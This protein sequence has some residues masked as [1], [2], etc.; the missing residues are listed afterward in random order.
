[1][2]TY[3]NKADKVTWKEFFQV[4]MVIAFP[5]A[6]Q[7][8]L[9]TTASMVDTIMIGSEGELAVAAVGIC[10]QIS[11]LYFNCYWGF[12]SGSVLFFSQYWGA[13]DEEG[14][15]RTLGISFFFMAVVAV[16]FSSVCIVFPDKMLAIYTDKQN[17]IE[18]GVPY[19]RIVGFSYILQVVTVI[20]S[21]LMRSTERIKQPLIGSIAGV[22][23]N[24]ILNWLLIYGRF[25]LPKLGAAGAAVGTLCS[26]VVN[27][28]ILTYYLVRTNDHVHLRK[29]WICRM[30]RM[31][32]KGYLMKCFP[33][34]CNEMLYGVGQMLINIV[35]GHQN[36]SA[37]AAMAAFRVCEGFVYAFFGGL[38]SATGVVVGKEVGGGR[39]MKAHGYAK[40]SAVVC[41]MVTF[42]IVLICVFVNR[43]LFGLFGL[44]ETALEYG[45]YMMLIYLFFG[46][47]RT[48]NYIMNESFRAGGE[49]VFG[50]VVE[51]ACLYAISVPATWLAGMTFHLQF[52]LVFSFV[53]TD[54]ILRLFILGYY[55]LAGKWVKPVT[56]QG[57]AA[58][59]KF[60]E[61]MKMK[62]IIKSCKNIKNNG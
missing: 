32:V 30:D 9:G 2:N 48:C 10:S 13:K 51:I 55:M 14:I 7:N 18:I 58:L 53:Y 15:N 36:E 33:I 34:I 31:F 25:G 12:A 47:I 35:I 43:P 22:I 39:L 27:L 11:S 50:T 26:A 57:Q 56:A 62:K 17:I 29:E 4:V 46:T 42:L 1:M 49:S 52:L 20:I 45:K 28:L 3:R 44:G 8:L 19:L 38:A 54:E 60:R 61:K 41:P 21:T 59:P 24:F 5:I 23:V 16:L 6:I 37:I 40:H